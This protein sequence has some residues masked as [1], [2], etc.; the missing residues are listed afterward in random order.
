M[1]NAV[2][3]LLPCALLGAVLLAGVPALASPASDGL[4]RQGLA[5]M[6]QRQF[7][8]AA[9]TFAEAVTA[10][11]ADGR[12]AFLRGI[13]LNRAGN[14]LG[15]LAALQYARV[16]GYR[17]P[18]LDYEAGW[19]AVASG[20]WAEGA[21]YLEDY[22]KS[23]PG[24][25]KVSEWLARAYLALG[26]Y[27]L[28]EALFHQAMERDADGTRQTALLG[29]AE[30][31]RLKG[32][33]RGA[34]DLARRAAAADPGSPVG[35]VVRE[36]LADAPADTKRPWTAYAAIGVGHNDNVIALSDQIVRPADISSTGSGLLRFNAGGSWTFQP[37]AATTLTLAY[38][39]QLDDYWRERFDNI[40]SHGLGL[41]LRTPVSDVVA[42]QLG[43]S[44][45]RTYL[46]GARYTQSAQA[47]PA[48]FFRAGDNVV[49][50]A[51]LTAATADYPAPSVT[52]AQ[53]D[54]DS[55]TLTFGGNLHLQLTDP[56]LGIVLGAAGISN[57]AKGDDYDFDA[58]RLS[59]TLTAPL[60][61]RIVGEVRGAF[62]NYSYRN[63]NSLA[64]TN[65]PGPTGFGFTRQDRVINWGLR[66]TRPLTESLTA[67]ATLDWVDATSNL[68][69]FT[70]DQRV[71]LVGLIHRF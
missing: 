38:D 54:R 11:P 64:P 4:V 18:Q 37:G 15:A 21:Q 35:R 20:A 1:C 16:A 25:A 55:N 7:D 40:G 3:R 62:T 22:E 34:N 27:D 50:E 41:T 5:Q 33:R 66:F 23:R 19:A 32:N 65:P 67:F 14:P 63:L 61:W 24:N 48:L 28:A 58:K 26:Q 59:A 36:A 70:Y 60:P 57:E 8:A 2:V 52:P 13:A 42:I 31:E 45:G 29:L 69:V 47:R 39:F 12:A 51:F 17:H 53:L 10:D 46:D 30:I 43:V 6:E 49:F 71:A 9:L 56:P 44:G 68:P